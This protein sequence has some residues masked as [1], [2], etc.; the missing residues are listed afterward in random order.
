MSGFHLKRLGDPLNNDEKDDANEARHEDRGSLLRL[1]KGGN[2]Q[3]QED[4]CD[5]DRFDTAPARK[6][7]F[8][9]SE[10]VHRLRCIKKIFERNEK[11]ECPTERG[12]RYMHSSFSFLS[13]IF[14][15]QRRRC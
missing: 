15:I 11:E 9:P 14:L 12:D 7:P 6:V 5:L 2:E 4:K 10:P 3:D 1:K 13:N 8:D